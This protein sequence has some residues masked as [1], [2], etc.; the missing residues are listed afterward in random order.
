MAKI[1]IGAI[2][3]TH[4]SL[5]KITQECDV[6]FIA[7]DISPLEIQ[8]NSPR[9]SDWIFSRFVEWVKTIPSQAVVLIAGNHD[10]WLERAT[11]SQLYL[12]EK[13]TGH[14]LKYLKNEIWKFTDDDA[15]EWS[16]FGTPY[17]HFFGRWPFMRE[18]YILTQ[19]FAAIPDVVDIIVTHD[20]P[21]GIGNCDVILEKPR[22][23]GINTEDHCG[24]VE[25]A[26]KLKNVDFKLLMCGHIHSGSHEIEKKCV[27]V[28][29]LDEKY[30]EGTYDIFYTELE[31]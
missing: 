7:G 12:M 4:G 16:I 1:R 23:N 9:M 8:F 31:K 24:G 29:Y 26:E 6:F 28:S 13:E 14:K 21:F 30:S 17:C 3:D 19:H 10:A 27:N 2:S 11:E 22:L 18:P 15:I 25:L 20:P 5:P